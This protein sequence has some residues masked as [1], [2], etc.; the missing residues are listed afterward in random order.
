MAQREMTTSEFKMENKKKMVLH[1]QA[2]KIKLNLLQRK[3]QAHEYAFAHTFVS[4][5]L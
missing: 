4:R 1:S 3:K 5:F 2:P